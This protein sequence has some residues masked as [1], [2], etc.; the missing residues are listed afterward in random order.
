MPQYLIQASYTADAWAILVKKPQNRAE[1]IQ[2]LAK[3]LGG[4][5]ENAWLC[6][7]E[8]DVVAVLSMPGNV[9]A[10]AF[11]MAAMAGGALKSIK[12][13]PLFSYEEGIDAMQK[14]SNAGY[15]PP[16]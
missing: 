13:T 8:H 7:G 12:T 9:T 14:A 4:T 15:R 11:S 16:K 10:A 3:N 2:Q 1:A 5:L 6:L